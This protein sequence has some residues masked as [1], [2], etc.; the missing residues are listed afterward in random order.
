MKFLLSYRGIIAGMV[1]GAVAGYAY[2]HYIGCF[3]GTC[4]ITSQPFNSTVYGAVMGG[5]LLN[6]F[7]KP[8]KNQNTNQ[9]K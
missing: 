3:S 6:M 4:P 9:G 2:Y 5:L 7:R 1:A 8:D